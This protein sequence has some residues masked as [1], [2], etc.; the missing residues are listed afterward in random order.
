MELLQA[1]LIAG[2]A[3]SEHTDEQSSSLS[4]KRTHRRRHGCGVGT[5]REAYREDH[6][7]TLPTRVENSVF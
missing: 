2:S 6:V 5:P 4:R 1:Q 3:G 7:Q